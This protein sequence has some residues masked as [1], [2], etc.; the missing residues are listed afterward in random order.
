MGNTKKQGKGIQGGPGEKQKNAQRFA[1]SLISTVRDGRG[2]RTLDSPEA[3][4]EIPPGLLGLFIERAK[5]RN[6][7]DIL[8]LANPS[9]R[10]PLAL[11][12]AS[13]YSDLRE[14]SRVLAD[15]I[16]MGE[17]FEW[18]GILRSLV[19]GLAAEGF[20]L[21]DCDEAEKA[22]EALP[23]VVP[24]YR[25]GL[26]T[27]LVGP[28]FGISWTLSRD[29]AIWFASRAEFKE[30][31]PA[32]E[33]LGMGRRPPTALFE[34]K[35]KRADICGLMLER[36]EEEVLIVRGLRNVVSYWIGATR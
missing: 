28:R 9:R 7:S 6:P 18:A 26:R 8:I 29:K 16:Q 12:M 32:G 34:A 10:V 3:R 13:G 11:A 17:T 27:E 33:L 1:R 2:P 4:K 21:F 23:N 31:G 36:E 20:P 19:A 35:V 22:F 25:G 15:A 14:M 24:V 30:W 5:E